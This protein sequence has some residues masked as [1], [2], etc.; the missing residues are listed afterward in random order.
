[1]Q[2]MPALS[3]VGCEGRW[4]SHFPWRFYWDFVRNIFKFETFGVDLW[5]NHS[6]LVISHYGY[7]S[8][9][10]WLIDLS[11]TE[12]VCWLVINH[13]RWCVTVNQKYPFISSIP[14]INQSWSWSDLADLALPQ[15][16]P[17]P[18]SLDLLRSAWCPV[19]TWD[20][21]K[22]QGMLDVLDGWLIVG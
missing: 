16:C 9:Y 18:T 3:E 8:L 21:N 15:I 14:I 5:K 7:K 13:C 20:A 1:M 4:S 17:Y 12:F 10:S 6:W 2:P 22:H 11:Y 19:W